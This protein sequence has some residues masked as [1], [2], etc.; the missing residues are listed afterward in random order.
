MLANRAAYD[1]VI[2]AGPYGEP[3]DT[4][5]KNLGIEINRFDGQLLM[6]NPFEQPQATAAVMYGVSI[7]GRERGSDRSDEGNHQRQRP[8]RRDVRE[9]R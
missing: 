5:F 8:R 4:Q 7:T 9:S 1:K 2:D 6:F 3:L